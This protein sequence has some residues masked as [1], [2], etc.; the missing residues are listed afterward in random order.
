[1]NLQSENINPNLLK[2]LA[3]T[4]GIDLLEKGGE[5]SKGGK[6]IGHT[7]SGKP[8]YE[9]GA[10]VKYF[11]DG[12]GKHYTGTVVSSDENTGEHI[13]KRDGT[14]DHHS[15]IKAEDMKLHNGKS[16]EFVGKNMRR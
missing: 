1:M 9:K 11:H 6:V 13:I 5:G 15:E 16:P 4:Y 7:K 10:R 3:E 14:T 12:L 2:G 8:I